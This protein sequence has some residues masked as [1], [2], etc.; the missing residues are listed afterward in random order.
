MGK[1]DLQALT[2]NF[3]PWFWQ[4]DVNL[5][6]VDVLQSA[7]ESV[8]DDYGAAE[9]DFTERVGYSIQRLSLETGLNGRYDPLLLRIEVVNGEAQSDFV[10]NE[11]EVL[12][13]GQVERYVFNEGEVI[14]PSAS[15]IYTYSI[16]EPFDAVTPFTV[17]VPIALSGQEQGIRAFIDA[18]LIAGTEYILNFV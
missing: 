15:E 14:P 16:G 2:R 4:N 6:L 17:N 7:L 8:N 12:P 3:F 11:G 18:V 9:I 13:E 1:Y 10:F 5:S